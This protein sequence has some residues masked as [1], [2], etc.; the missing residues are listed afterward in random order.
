QLKT[1]VVQK[2]CSG[3]MVVPTDGGLVK[4]QAYYARVFAYSP[5]GFSQ[6]QVAPDPA[7]PTTVPGRPTSVSVEVYDAQSLKVVFSPPADDGGDTVVAYLVEWALDSTFLDALNST[8]SLLSG[9]APFHKVISNLD[10]GVAYYVRVSARNS[11]GYGATQSSSPTYQHPYEEPTAPTDVV[12]GVT[13]D[14]MLTVGWSAFY[15]PESNGGDDVTAFVIAWDVSESFNSLVGSPHT[16][17]ARVNSS[18]RAYTVQYLSTSRRYYVKVAAENSAGAGVAL[19]ASPTSAY[20]SQQVPGI[21]VGLVARN[22]TADSATVSW[23]F[24]LVP[25]H[26]I[27]CFGTEATPTICPTPVGGVYPGSDGGDDVYEYRIQWS[28]NLG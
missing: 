11:L 3:D 4:G 25:S 22:D 23:D 5:V 7:K 2:E 14:T 9:G 10:T 8:V 28:T 16:G 1:G 19:A 20:P 13:S 6:G 21:P 17:T 24:P 27:P 15:P 18:E 26:G 12:L